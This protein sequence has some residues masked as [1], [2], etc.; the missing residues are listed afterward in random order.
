M[1][2]SPSA[3]ISVDD[4]VDSGSRNGSGLGPKIPLKCPNALTTPEGPGGVVVTLTYR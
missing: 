3:A 2:L 4:L 1:T